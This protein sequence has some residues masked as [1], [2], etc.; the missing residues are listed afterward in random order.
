M[1][2]P[3]IFLNVTFA[4]T[5]LAAMLALHGW[6]ILGDG[7]ATRL[8]LRPRFRLPSVYWTEQAASASR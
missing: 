7:A 6:A 3:L 8:R 1:T 5:V 4:V 2:A